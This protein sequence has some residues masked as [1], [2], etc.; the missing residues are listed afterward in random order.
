MALLFFLNSFT[1]KKTNYLYFLI[2]KG[3]N[4]IHTCGKFRRHRKLRKYN[5]KS[6]NA[7]AKMKPSFQVTN[8]YQVKRF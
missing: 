8:F 7:I 3:N 1:L 2:T 6:P 5:E 4:L